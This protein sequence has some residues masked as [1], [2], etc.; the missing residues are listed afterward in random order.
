MGVYN[1]ILKKSLW[2]FHMS[3][4]PCNNCDIEVL[5]L[6][7]PGYDLERFGIK[8]VGS[9]R[10]ADVLLITGVGGCK[11]AERVVRVYNQAPKPV[12]VVAVGTCPIGGATFKD[13]Y[14]RCGPLDELIPVNLY[15]PGCPP[16][17]ETMIEGLLKLLGRLE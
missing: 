1:R 3:A 13:S 16:K 8:L 6:L 12:F 7:T 4:S 11:V 15:I 17:P 5:D 2:V 10:H 14:S 9:I